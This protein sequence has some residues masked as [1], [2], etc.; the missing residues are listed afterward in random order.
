MRDR[1]TH[2]HKQRRDRGVCAW[3]GLS[4]NKAGRR[5]LDPGFQRGWQEPSFQ[6]GTCRL[7]VYTLAKRWN[8]KWSWEL[9]LGTRTWFSDHPPWHFSTRPNFCS[10]VLILAVIGQFYHQS[11]VSHGKATCLTDFCLYTHMGNMLLHIVGSFLHKGSSNPQ[12]FLGQGKQKML[13]CLSVLLR[14]GQE[15]YSENA[16]ASCL[17]FKTV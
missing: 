9:S 4:Q 15:I 13:F 8:W 10:H 1:D 12:G 17:Q 3:P 14:I 6:A 2:T 16:A 11:N 5:E 7:S